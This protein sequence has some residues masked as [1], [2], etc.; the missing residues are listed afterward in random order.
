MPLHFF[1]L[2]YDYNIIVSRKN[3]LTLV[4]VAIDP[5][6]LLKIYTSQVTSG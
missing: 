6:L 5:R 3:L 1:F 2:R 4:N